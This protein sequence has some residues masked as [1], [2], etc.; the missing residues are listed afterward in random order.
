MSPPLISRRQPRRR[1]HFHYAS[2]AAFAHAAIASAA[3]ITLMPLSLLLRS[4]L[5]YIT[6]LMLPFSCHG[7]RH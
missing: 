3:A 6:P 4:R 7:F 2:Y 1:R 5:P